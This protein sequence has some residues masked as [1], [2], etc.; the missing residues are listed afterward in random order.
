MGRRS[1][2][3][4]GIIDCMGIEAAAAVG[5]ALA[6]YH[7]G[8]IPIP[9]RPGMAIVNLARC[10]ALPLSWSWSPRADSVPWDPG[11]STRKPIF[12]LSSRIEFS[13]KR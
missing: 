5:A 4:F 10:V 1:A 9:E 2:R 3:R 12:C 11:L 13:D 6:R 7:L 8:R